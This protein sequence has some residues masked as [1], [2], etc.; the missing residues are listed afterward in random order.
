[1]LNHRA[2]ARIGASA[3]SRIAA[4]M[5]APTA[6]LPS[7]TSP[8]SLGAEMA[9]GAETTPSAGRER[10]PTP[11]RFYLGLAAVTLSLGAL[12]LLAPS[13]PSYDPWSWT[14]WAREIIHGH[15]V[16]TDTGTSWKPLP[17]V[18]TIPFALAG[19]KAAPELWLAVA[20]AGAIAGVLMA[21]RLAHRLT[22]AIADARMRPS[23][24]GT[25]PPRLAV[26]G[27]AL[28]AGAVALVALGFAAKGS[29]IT[30]NGLGYSDALA[31]ALLL[32]A[33]E[34][35]L[36]GRHRATFMVGFLVALDR[37]EIWLFWV[38]YG[39]WLGWRDARMRA[40]IAAAFVLAPIAWFLPVYLGSGH[41]GASVAR[42]TNPRA[43]SLAYAS[44]PFTAELTRAA[45]PTIMLRIKI[46]A[47]AL[48]A[49]SPLVLWRMRRGG[50]PAARAPWARPVLSAAMLGLGGGAWF[51]VIALMTQIGFSGNDRYLVLGAALVDVCGAVAF[52]WLAVELTRA[53]LALRGRG[54][55]AV[56]VPTAAL[57]GT[58]LTAAAFAML[59]A[60]IARQDFV[61]LPKVHGALLYQARLRDELARAIA[62]AGGPRHV[63]GCGRVMT[64]GF[65]VPMVAY[66]L[67]VPTP[68]ILAPP[69]PGQPGP[70]PN[71]ILQTRATRSSALLP[72]VRTWNPAR[73]TYRGSAGP[74]NTFTS[75]C[76]TGS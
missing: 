33:I 16:I 68:R 22:A 74:W 64:E 56:A 58:A 50:A 14:L 8:A 41:F 47:L 34:C 59:P 37:P 2:G 38:P 15:L 36:D 26:Q 7:V 42:A 61:S 31:G 6:Q 19:A 48:V 60:W 20:R 3:P 11:G 73:Y 65:Q 29:Y 55:R 46:M 5:S 54:R 67:D 1:L 4:A 10:R 25:A 12:S 63:L 62:L 18:L 70:A 45:L 76:A 66:A 52:G 40:L 72:V 24:G 17:M 30:A 53:V 51:V 69:A 27:P 35:H 32:I 13:T 9:L 75:D 43:N 21:F 57:A 44:D 71:V 49:V 39:L 28:L 23:P